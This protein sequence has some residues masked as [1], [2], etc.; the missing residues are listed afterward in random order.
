MP[1]I[2]LLLGNCSRLSKDRSHR[3]YTTSQLSNVLNSLEAYL[4]RHASHRDM[5]SS[6]MEGRRT[7]SSHGGIHLV[8]II[9]TPQREFNASARRPLR[10]RLSADSADT[11]IALVPQW[12]A[13]ISLDDVNVSLANLG[14]VMINAIRSFLGFSVRNRESITVIAASSSGGRKILLENSSVN[15]EIIKWE[16]R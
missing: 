10:F 6:T 7:T 12:G 3:Y 9:D 1:L 2:T 13:F 4:G 11:S 14:G 5:S 8:V 15:G 16:V